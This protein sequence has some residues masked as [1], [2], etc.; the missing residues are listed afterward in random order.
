MPGCLPQDLCLGES[1]CRRQDVA[2]EIKE[3]SA[4]ITRQHADIARLNG[5]LADTDAAQAGLEDDAL[6]L[7]GQSTQASKVR[8]NTPKSN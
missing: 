4:S 8:V 3:L 7:Q 5:M 1:V 2:K 6:R